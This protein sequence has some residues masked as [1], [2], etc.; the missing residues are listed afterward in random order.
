MTS[1]TTSP[2]IAHEVSDFLPGFA[3]AI[4]PELAAVFDGE[5][6][7]LRAAGVPDGAVQVGA[8]LPDAVVLDARGAQHDL[9]ALLEGRPAVI[10][11]YRGAWCPFCNITLRHY[12]QTLLPALAERGVSL[13]AISPQTPDGTASAI[14]KGDLGFTVVSDPGNALAGVLGIVTA[15]ST[16]AQEAHTALGFAVKDSNADDTA[17]IPFPTVLVVDADRR[18][19]L[20]DI[21]VDY[22]QRT[23][24]TEILRAV[25]AI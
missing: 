12:Q 10:V 3:D 1:T 16:A 11:F 18:I 4:G 21:K 5:Q 17:A 6:A 9:G 15:P 25:D 14:E 8:V 19:A 20:A 24:T 7:D 13:V 22:T 2:T 23:E